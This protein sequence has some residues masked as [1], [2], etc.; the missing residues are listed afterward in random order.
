M[1]VLECPV[2]IVPCPTFSPLTIFEIR[3]GDPRPHEDRASRFQRLCQTYAL[4]PIQ[5][6]LLMN[7]GDDA[8]DAFGRIKG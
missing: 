2:V 6:R 1:N 7:V 8:I 5:L 3:F 4:E